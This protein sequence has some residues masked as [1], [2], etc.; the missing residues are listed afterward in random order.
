M[1][2]THVHVYVYTLGE[3]FG[4]LNRGSVLEVSKMWLELSELVN[5]FNFVVFM[6]VN[7]VRVNFGKGPCAKSKCEG[8]L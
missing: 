2:V 6:G 4:I 3:L 1:A 7:L 8:H 5:F